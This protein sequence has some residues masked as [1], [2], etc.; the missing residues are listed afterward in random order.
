MSW[1]YNGPAMEWP[2]V[3]PAFTLTA[4]NVSSK[5]REHGFRRKRVLRMAGWMEVKRFHSEFDSETIT[6]ELTAVE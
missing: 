3:H 2:L 4:V 6:A 1:K 5:P